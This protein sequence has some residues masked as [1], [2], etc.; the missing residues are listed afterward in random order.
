VFANSKPGA[1]DAG[2]GQGFTSEDEKLPYQIAT[3]IS[4]APKAAATAAKRRYDAAIAVLL[5]MRQRFPATFAR[6]NARRRQ[7]I[8]IGVHN[9]L[10][11][12][13]P[14]L[15]ASDIALALGVYTT[16][17]GYLA[18][19][20][21]GTP[22]LGLDGQAAGAVSAEEAAH[23]KN[24]LDKIE[25]RKGRSSAASAPALAPKAKR[26]TLA[27]LRKAAERRRQRSERQA[28]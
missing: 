18:A 10:A 16:S 2:V 15:A 13:M 3:K 4:T 12:A 23:A 7:P 20:T 22:R 27:D 21:E 17:A 28:P 8:K 6:L 5:E 26:V 19:C 14:E 11:A 1:R 25:A 9:D 24:F